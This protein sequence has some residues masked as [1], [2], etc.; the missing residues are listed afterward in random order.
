MAR[1]RRKTIHGHVGAGAGQLG[2][3]AREGLPDGTVKRSCNWLRWH[4]MVTQPK[5]SGKG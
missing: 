4:Q 1:M 3:G 5:E 2:F